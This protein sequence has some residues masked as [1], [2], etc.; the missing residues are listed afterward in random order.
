MSA[1]FPLGTVYILEQDRPD[2]EVVR[3]LE[4]IAE[5]GLTRVVFWP[6]ARREPEGGL[7]PASFRQGELALDTCA[8]LG[9]EAILELIGQ[10]ASQE[11]LPDFLL[12]EE[13]MVISGEGVDRAID[14]WPN[15]CHPKVQG[16]VREYIRA[17]V[18]HYR[19]H[20]A[21]FGWDIFNEAHFRS[22]DAFTEKEFRRWLATRYGTAAALN[23]CWGRSYRAIDQVRLANLSFNASLW[24]SLQPVLDLSRFFAEIV[25]AICERW[26]AW[27]RE[28]D[29]RHPVIVDNAHSLT[30]KDPTERCDD[31][32]RTAGSADIFG[33]SLYPKSWGNAYTPAMVFQSVEA[34]RSAAEGAGR[35]LMIS[36]L[37]THYQSALTPGSEVSPEE[38]RSW[39]WVALACGV[40]SL[41]YWRWRPFLRGYQI[42]GRGLTTMDGG[43]SPRQ[44]AVREITAT[45]AEWGEDFCRSRPLPARIGLLYSYESALA[46]RCLRPLV[47][48]LYERNFHGWYRALWERNLLT[49]VLRAELIDI[50]PEVRLLVL[51]CCLVVTEALAGQLRRF[52]ERGGTLVADARLGISDAANR[53]HL[54][55]PGPGLSSLFGVRETDLRGDEFGF[56]RQELALAGGAVDRGG[57]VEYRNS[58]YL[59][60]CAGIELLRRN[61]GGLLDV[62]QAVGFRSAVPAEVT[63]ERHSERYQ[64]GF[65]FD[66]LTGFLRRVERREEGG[67]G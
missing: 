33:L 43:S 25:A 38:L 58:Y 50:P 3:D 56:L 5:T 14:H 52:V 65:A 8:R 57:Y 44:E 34:A 64:Y 22:Y 40:D 61:R 67:T 24:S 16:A 49:T 17:V 27:V 4:R 10:N 51:P 26:A 62:L 48:D 6:A 66:A 41:V 63:R 31:D 42:T 60:T 23:R 32:W 11:Y 35:P 12:D 36:E 45:L 59:P 18:P 28:L 30:L 7:G 29:P 19:G 46:S 9:M 54:S 13:D 21:L 1:M 39:T 53:A 15:L 47:A 37:Q 2:A 55:I 20:P